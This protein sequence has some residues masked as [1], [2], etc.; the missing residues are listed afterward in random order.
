MSAARA[1][2]VKREP[3]TPVCR[4]Y[5][6]VTLFNRFD[7]WVFVHTVRKVIRCKREPR[8]SPREQ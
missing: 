1:V 7:F 2:Y 4:I 3:V 5:L 8:Q 6:D